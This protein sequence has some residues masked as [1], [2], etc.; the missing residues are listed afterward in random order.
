MEGLKKAKGLI[1]DKMKGLRKTHQVL[2]KTYKVVHANNKKYLRASLKLMVCLLDRRK[3]NTI[4]LLNIFFLQ[5][6]KC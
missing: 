2:I 3:V 1:V 5:L 6:Q 4:P